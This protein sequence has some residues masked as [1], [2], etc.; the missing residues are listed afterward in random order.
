MNTQTDVTAQAAIPEQPGSTQ[1]LTLNSEGQALFG[2]IAANRRNKPTPDGSVP[3]PAGQAEASQTSTPPEKEGVSGDHDAPDS[4]VAKAETNEEADTENNSQSNVV[5]IINFAKQN[6]DVVF[7]IANKDAPNGYT[8]VPAEKAASILGQ[9]GAVNEKANKLKAERAEF[10]EQM[11]ERQKQVDG[12]T[13]ALELEIV[14]ALQKAG[15]ELV[16]LQDYQAQW[17]EYY[18]SNSHDPAAQ[19]QA[20]SAMKKNDALIQEAT[21]FIKDKRPKVAYYFEQRAKQMNDYLESSRKNFQDTELKNSHNFNELKTT[22]EKSWGNAKVQAIPGVSNID[23]V[24]SDE[25]L[26]GLLRDGLKFRKTP[27]ANSAGKSNVASSNTAK[28][29]VTKIENPTEALQRKSQSGD[30]Q[31][32]FDLLTAHL[33]ARRK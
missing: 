26:L 29:A 5:D 32:S 27:K 12:L 17:R 3:P 15:E 22:L 24:S 23:L 6:K 10:E 18:D 31:A 11:S 2:L 20:V 28:K 30:R 16:Q 1:D 7:R 21:Q 14:P 25:Y 4:E 33:N 19:A 8:E 9:A 13:L